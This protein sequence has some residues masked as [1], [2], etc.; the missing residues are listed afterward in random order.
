MKLRGDARQFISFTIGN[1]K[2]IQIWFDNWH[3]E[4][5]LFE[6]YE[7]RVINDAHSKLEAHLNYVIDDGHWNWKLSRSD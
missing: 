2:N 6:K 7:H 3:Q 5:G 4:G 1:G